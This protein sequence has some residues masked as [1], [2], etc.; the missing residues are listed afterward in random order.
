MRC[1]KM[2]RA[3]ARR[4]LV[5]EWIEGGASGCWAL[6]AIGMSA[7]ALHH[8]QCEGRNVELREHIVALAHRHTTIAF[9]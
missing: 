6:A 5:C 9:Q 2:V 7:G 1:K 4:A 3:P 8:R